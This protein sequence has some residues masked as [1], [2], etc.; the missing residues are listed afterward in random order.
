MNR[1]EVIAIDFDGTITL[2][3]PYP[4]TGK[5]RPEAIEVI[6]RIK[7]KYKILLWT[8]RTDKDLE[9]AISLLKQYDIEFDYICKLPNQK[10]KPNVKY[11]ID[12]RNLGFVVDWYKI[13]ELLEV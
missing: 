12:D 11:F 4:I 5:I 3:S 6:K 9:E 2:P 1:D 8:L 7:N 10:N 13:A